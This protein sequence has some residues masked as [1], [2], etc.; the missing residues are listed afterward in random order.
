MTPAHLFKI[1]SCTKTFVAAT[2]M[3]LAQDGAVDL[4]APVATWF[5]TLANAERIRVRQLVDHTA[6]L[7]EFEYDMPVDPDRIWTPAQIVALAESVGGAD[8]PGRMCSYNNTGY[9]LAGQLIEALTGQTLAAAIRARVLDRLGLRD[10]FAAAG[11]AF[12]E[13]RLARGYYH[14]P[15]PQ[16]PEPATVTEGREMWR[17]AGLLGYSDEL[18]DSTTLFPMTGAYAAGDMIGCTEESSRAS[19]T[20][21]WPATCWVRR[22]GR[23]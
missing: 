20:R 15:A 22:C 6:G 10:S 12:P 17:T 19:C 5:P 21:W 11:E 3:S 4:A 18:Q 8:E 2:L 14:R 16:G 7:P 13:V 9:V 1:A 23:K